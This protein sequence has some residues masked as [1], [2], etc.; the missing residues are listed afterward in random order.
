MSPPSMELKPAIIRRRVMSCRSRRTKQNEQLTISDLQVQ[1]RDDH[2]I[3]ISALPSL[4][5]ILLISPLLPFELLALQ[6][7]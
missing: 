1:V 6:N 2:I 4:T 7:Q 3:P 5:D